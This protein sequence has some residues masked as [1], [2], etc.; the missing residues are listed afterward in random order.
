MVRCPGNE[1]VIIPRMLYPCIDTELLMLTNY[2]SV[3]GHSHSTYALKCQK[4]D[5]PFPLVR[6]HTFYIDPLPC[7]RTFRM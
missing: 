5:T 6:M 4:L 2:F 1:V 3:R 7:V